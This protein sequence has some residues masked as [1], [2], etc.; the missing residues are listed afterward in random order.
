MD[1]RPHCRELLLHLRYSV[2]E[3]HDMPAFSPTRQGFRTAFRRPSLSFAEIVWRWS[4]GAV[5]L[6]LL[7]FT[8][9]EYFDTLPVSK[10]DA[11]L[12]ASRHAFL[13][14]RAIVHIFRGSVSR[15][16]LT[17][18]LGLLAFSAFWILAASLGRVATLKALSYADPASEQ[19]AAGFRAF[20]SLIGLNFLRVVAA[21]AA[22]LALFSAT[23]IANISLASFDASFQAVLRFL[24]FVTLSAGVVLIWVLLNWLLSFASIFSVQRQD[25]QGGLVRTGENTIG[26]IT[27]ALGLLN[28][29]P[30][31]LLA[32]S[33]WN[34]MAHV[35][36]LICTASAVSVLFAFVTIAP[37]LV[38][39]GFVL[40]ALAYFAFVDWLYIARL[41]G[42]MLVAEMPEAFSPSATLAVNP[43]GERG[44]AGPLQTAIDRDEPILSDLPGM[45]SEPVS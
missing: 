41:A 32:V 13:V 42:Y 30:G 33:T 45:A 40:I 4:V 12:L 15:A 7:A 24:I 17:A 23:V 34:G 6:A 36:A 28:E 11:D 29:R 21:L 3:Q 44:S 26:A 8:A 1:A 9:V 27:A 31:P 18:L 2:S 38:V 37:R 43:P 35:T 22:L 25:L 20:R 14:W 5:S 39:F 10:L 19:S 16:T